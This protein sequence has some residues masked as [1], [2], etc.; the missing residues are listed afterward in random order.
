MAFLSLF[1]SDH[2]FIAPLAI[3]IIGR[4]VLLSLSAFY[5]RF[6]SL[7]H[8]VCLH[9]LPR[10]LF[11]IPSSF[12]RKRSSAIGTFQYL[13]LKFILPSSA[14]S[15]VR[16]QNP[17]LRIPK[18]GCFPSIGEHCLAAPSYGCDH[19]AP[20]STIR[21]RNRAPE[22][23]VRQSAICYVPFA[24]MPCY[25]WT[26]AVTTI[27]SGLSYVFSKNAVRILSERRSRK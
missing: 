27:W 11:I 17:S 23:T 2:T 8:P 19:R 21:S 9:I 26:V 16:P 5:I 1:N 7:P 22:S 15:V 4:D 6:T 24:H 25:R 20:H 3:I 14:R 12:F 10:Y 13:R 18:R